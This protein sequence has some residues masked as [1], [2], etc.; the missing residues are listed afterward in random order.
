MQQKHFPDNAHMDNYSEKL[1]C[2]YLG[3]DSKSDYYINHKRKWVSAVC[4]EEPWD[5]ESHPYLM[6]KEVN[7]LDK[8]LHWRKAMLNYPAQLEE[9]I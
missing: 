9:D 3:L 8:P 1:G 5:Y 2:E 4:G 7:A 6:L